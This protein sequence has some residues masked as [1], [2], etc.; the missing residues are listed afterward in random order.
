MQETDRTETFTWGQN[1]RIKL[2]HAKSRGEE[3]PRQGR[4]AEHKGKIEA[5]VNPT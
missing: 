3:E 5:H 4:K 1:R 2:E